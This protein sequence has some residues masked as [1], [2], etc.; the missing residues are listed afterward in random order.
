MLQE[1][2]AD[3][4][5]ELE[6][7]RNDRNI[8]EKKQQQE[9]SAQNLVVFE[10][11]THAVAAPPNTTG[12]A[13]VAWMGKCL[14]QTGFPLSLPC[15]PKLKGGAMIARCSQLEQTVSPCTSKELI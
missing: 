8:I 6:K 4:D 2:S 3:K 11:K 7:V 15:I 13:V 12:N 9:V 14:M 1:E 10:P 5:S